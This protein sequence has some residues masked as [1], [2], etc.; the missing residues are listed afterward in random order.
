[1][2]VFVWIFA[3]IL[4]FGGNQAFRLYFGGNQLHL[5]GLALL[6]RAKFIKYGPRGVPLALK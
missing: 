6:R 2:T 3:G 1:M 4:Y 5:I